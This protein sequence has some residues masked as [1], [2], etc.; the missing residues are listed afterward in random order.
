M[1]RLL[2][3]F[4]FLGGVILVALN[5]ITSPS[6]RRVYASENPPG[7]GMATSGA[8]ASPPS[9]T[10][11]SS[12]ATPS[13]ERLIDCR[14]QAGRILGATVRLGVIARQQ[15]GGGEQLLTGHGTVMAGRYVLTHNHYGLTPEEFGEGRLLSLS[16]DKADG[17]LAV[18]DVLPGSFSVIAVGPEVL[19][20]DFGEYGG[21]GLFG[22]I[23]VASADFAP[24]DAVSLQA[25]DEVAQI[26]WDGLTAHVVWARVTAVNMENGTPY[27]ELDTFVRPGASGGGVFYHGIHIANN[28][29]RT[30][31][32]RGDT[33]E[34]MRRYSLAAMNTMYV[35]A[36]DTDAP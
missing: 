3:R 34:I 24:G 2:A 13:P 27:V 20:L 11:R 22:V 36:L 18:K 31:D 35:V 4:G 15:D 29:S 7:E 5:L 32:L 6:V 9:A 25:G 28:W 26:D 23:D 21:R 30:T 1:K 8:L 10:D 19:L 33:G 16:I 12:C 14:A 17:S